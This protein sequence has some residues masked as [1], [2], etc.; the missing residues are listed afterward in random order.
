MLLLR[1]FGGFAKQQSLQVRVAKST[2]GPP[3]LADQ[4]EQGTVGTAEGMQATL[5]L[6]HPSGAPAILY[7]SDKFAWERETRFG[8]GRS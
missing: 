2:Q 7:H 8:Y 5:A 1:G 3:S 6:A 4:L